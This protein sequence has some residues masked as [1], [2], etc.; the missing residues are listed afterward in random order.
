MNV[1][2]GACS[3]EPGQPSP[4]RSRRDLCAAINP[5]RQGTPFEQSPSFNAFVAPGSAKFGSCPQQL[6]VILLRERGRPA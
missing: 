4:S 5:V 1:A 6:A 2:D 3:Y